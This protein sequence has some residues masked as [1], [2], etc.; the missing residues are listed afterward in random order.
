MRYLA[1]DIGTRHTGTAYLDDAVGIPLPLDT[2]HHVSVDAL[3]DAV[4][5]IIKDRQIEKVIVGLPLLL[6]GE[7]GSQSR[8]VRT[9]AEML[10]KRGL[11]V[12]FVDERFSSPRSKGKSQAFDGDA[13]AACQILASIRSI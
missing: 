3:I 2:V 11:T 9:I 12:N 10:E 6:S 8:F 5:R 1:L 4:L 7:E 13:A